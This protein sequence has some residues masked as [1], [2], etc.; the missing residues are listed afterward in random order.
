MIYCGNCGARF[1][2]EHGNYSCY[3]RTK[4][5]TKYIK[6]PSC[7]NKKWKI[8]ELDQAIIDFIATL[9][10]DDSG[11]SKDK[12]NEKRQSLKK[13]YSNRIGDIDKQISKLID[14]YQV[15][16]IPIEI[17]SKKIDA[18]AREKAALEEDASKDAPR[19]MTA[20]E[21]IAIRNRF[22]DLL[23]NGALEE[24]RA[25]VAGLIRR[26]TITGDDVEITLK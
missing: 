10:F 17:I 3:S 8:E 26:I 24:K 2:G 9:G 7:K 12:E 18:L 21:R 14:L 1:H 15:G 16:S 20:A 11:D 25:C 5:D 13:D 6:D 23:D 19:V 4:G 22:M